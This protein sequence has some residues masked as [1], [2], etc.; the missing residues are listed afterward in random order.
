MAAAG[1]TTRRG[2]PLPAPPAR[3]DA[4]RRPQRDGPR[5]GRGGQRGRHPDRAARH[6]LPHQRLRRVR[7]RGRRSATPTATP[8]GGPSGWRASIDP[9]HATIGAA[10]HSVRAV[11]RDQ[12]ATVVEAARD[13]PLHVHLSEQVA[14]NDACLATYG[15]TPT[16][17]LHDAGA[18]GPL[19]TRRARHPP[20]AAPTSPTSAQTGTRACFCPTTER[21]L[22]DGIGPSRALRQAG[23]DA[24][25]R[26]RQPR[27]DRPLRGDARAGDG[28]AARHPAARPLDRRRADRG[29][30]RPRL[31]R[32]RR[33]RHASRSVSAPTS[34]P[35]PRRRRGPPAPAPTRTPPSSPPPPP[36]SPTS[37]STAGSSRPV[38]T[39][40][41]IGRDL[42][43]AIERVNP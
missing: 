24:H 15:V 21:D 11:P 19:T 3:R 20:D 36:T 43:A 6:L 30:D 5:A 42:A 18:L 16:Q 2:V 4:V 8:S 38:T 40:E 10:I 1:I 14:E 17:L 22:G 9:D 35:S 13:R 31:A 33:R 37:S 32:L 39:S 28:R 25:P 41:Q 7:P 12:L 23:S 29:R 34:S 27:G 26:L